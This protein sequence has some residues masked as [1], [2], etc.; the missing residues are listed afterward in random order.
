MDRYKLKT[1][2]L[3]YLL[4]HTNTQGLSIKKL[5]EGLHVYQIKE[6]KIKGTEIM[7]VINSTING[8]DDF[9]VMQHF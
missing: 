8:C 7:L 3:I 6:C 1:F 9:K 4:L 2:F 5:S